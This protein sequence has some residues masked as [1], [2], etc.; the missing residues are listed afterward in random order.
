[1]WLGEIGVYNYKARMYWPNERP[2]G[3]F[4]QAD[5]VGYAPGMNRYVYVNDNPVNAVDPS[6]REGRAFFGVDTDDRSPTRDF[7]PQGTGWGRHSYDWM[8]QMGTPVS[9][10]LDEIRIDQDVRR[11]RLIALSN[12]GSGGGYLCVLF[13][14]Q[15]GLTGSEQSFYQSFGL[16]SDVLSNTV[17][18]QGLPAA[19]FA[20]PSVE[21]H[22]DHN[23]V[24][25]RNGIGS[26]FSDP[27]RTGMIG[28]E[29]YHVWQYSKGANVVSFVAQYMKYG[30]WKSPLEVSAYNFGWAIERCRRAST[31]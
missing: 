26:A 23:L 7:T 12:N 20:L 19:F 25:L 22:T 11:Q 18:V 17:L 29:L 15:R 2:G 10:R 16:P 28:H 30:Y 6:G 5:P 21:G 14:P 13:C 9:G 4:L 8:G 31:C 24:F 27:Y 1:M 3:R